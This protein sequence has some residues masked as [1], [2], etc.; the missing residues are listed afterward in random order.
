MKKAGEEAEVE[1]EKCRVQRKDLLCNYDR[2]K[3]QR[4]LLVLKEKRKGYPRRKIVRASRPPLVCKA[5]GCMKVDV[6]AGY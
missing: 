5:R 3:I 6:G 2:Q 4:D 1:I